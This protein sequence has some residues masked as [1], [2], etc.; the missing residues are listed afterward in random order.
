V[1]FLDRATRRGRSLAEAAGKLDLAPE[2]LKSWKRRHEKKRLVPRRLGRPMMP[3]PL[4]T[5]IA[6]VT[7]FHVFGPRIGV[8][9]A[10]RL[11]PADPRRALRR[12]VE[13]LNRAH[14]RKH[15]RLVYALR[16][17]RPGAVW[18]IDFSDPP[19]PLDGGFTKILCVRD[20]GS[21]RMLLAL[22]APGATAE[23]AR[24]ALEALFAEHGPPLVL[25]FDNGSHFIAAEI[26]AL[27]AEHSV[28]ALVSP[29]YFP[30]FNGS[31]EAGIGGLKT[32]ALFA[33]A[34]NDRAACWTGDDLE[35]GRLSGNATAR[36]RGPAGPTP[37]ELWRAR[38][39]ITAA[40]REAFRQAVDL[41]L[42]EARAVGNT[43]ADR[44]RD[45]KEVA[46]IERESIAR[47]L[48]AQG[49]L[50]VR[51]RRVRPSIRAL[52]RV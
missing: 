46:T 1:A 50:E 31:I 45:R 38:A 30:E 13:R 9:L 33:A 42:A 32:R 34:R 26:A 8:P 3:C 29:P 43:S 2:T 12:Q 18:A 23:V 27:L 51:R 19:G 21:G 7:L 10:F 52:K 24:A 40:E 16:W 44:G 11:F 25:K 6:L 5:R 15:E 41:E 49:L 36:P 14:C 35:T 47:A 28:I 4:D 48:V 17:T 20:L 37:D 39:P 22:A